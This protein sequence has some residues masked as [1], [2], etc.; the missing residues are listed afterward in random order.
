MKILEL[1]INDLFE[2]GIR[3]KKNRDY[4]EYVLQKF[5]Q[6][7]YTKEEKNITINTY[8]KVGFFSDKIIF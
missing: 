8:K 1:T 2:K 4:L 5:I 6:G 3:N 7:N